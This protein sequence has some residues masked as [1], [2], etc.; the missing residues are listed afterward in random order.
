MSHNWNRI[1]QLSVIGAACSLAV[2]IGTTY[3]QEESSVL[4]N[5]PPTTPQTGPVLPPPANPNSPAT[6]SSPIS[7]PVV[8]PLKLS[9]AP[10]SL[11]TPP[12]SRSNTTVKRPFLR[13]A[14]PREPAKGKLVVGGE[15]IP[16]PQSDPQTVPGPVVPA[17]PIDVNV[18]P[19][20]PIEYDTDRDAR[21]MYRTGKIDLVM[22]TKN[23]A[24]GCAY[25]IPMC[26][27]ACCEGEP[28]VSGGR[29]IL[30]RGIV[31]YRWACGFR[32][33]VKFRHIRGDV[34]VEYEGD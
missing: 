31:E 10:E 12:Q 7:E 26:I 25:E 29:G 24:D 2:W 3:A 23:P 21:K 20:P 8:P 9:P 17:P 34:E 27:P 32:A 30:G 19:T 18:K 11:P 33:I 6:S 28:S 1:A 4:V 22:L 14:Q 13:P 5:T 16:M 15:S